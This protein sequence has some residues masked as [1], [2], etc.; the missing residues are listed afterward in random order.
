MLSNDLSFIILSNFDIDDIDYVI[1]NYDSSSK[2]NQD[3]VIQSL[4]DIVKQTTISLLS[5]ETSGV[6][7]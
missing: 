5:L 7:A 3:F 6:S 1:S 4:E 2:E